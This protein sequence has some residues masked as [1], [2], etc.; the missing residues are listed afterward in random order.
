[1]KVYLAADKGDLGCASQGL[2]VAKEAMNKAVPLKLRFLCS[3]FYFRDFDFNTL[4]TLFPG[5]EIDIFVDS[6][7]YS[8]ATSGTTIR[9]ED[10]I[11]WVR[12][13]Q[14][15][16]TVASA[17]DV[18][19]DAVGTERETLLM[20]AAGLKIP[21]LPVYHVGEPWPVL[22]KMAAESEYIALG[23]MVPYAKRGDFLKAWCTKAFT[24]IPKKTKVH[25]F[26]MTN[27]RTMQ[28][29]PWYSVDS[30]SWTSWVRYGQFQLFDRGKM[31]DVQMTNRQ[32]LLKQGDLLRRYGLNA[33]TTVSRGQSY[34]RNAVVRATLLSWQ[35]AE[36]WMNR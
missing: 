12:K 15:R 7:A 14:H 3:Y 8:A 18:I 5:Q 33:R 24:M 13:W 27:W 9:T 29:F 1:M 23:G 16:L 25:G 34:D 21:V 36:N 32:Q 11:E 31:V 10:Y 19:G 4:E 2:K 22:A 17:P 26:G 35:A 28:L 20:Q 6:G 30:S